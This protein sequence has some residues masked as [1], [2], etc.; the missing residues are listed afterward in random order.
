MVFDK[1]DVLTLCVFEDLTDYIAAPRD[2]TSLKYKIK[3][4]NFFSSFWEKNGQ[5]L[6][7]DKRGGAKRLAFFAFLITTQPWLGKTA[8]IYG[9]CDAGPAVLIYEWEGPKIEMREVYEAEA[10]CVM[11]V[12]DSEFRQWHVPPVVGLRDPDAPLPFQQSLSD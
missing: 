8:Y 11:R 6:Y 4:S 1:W 12:N 5:R 9:L 3:K 7:I 10:C 2:G